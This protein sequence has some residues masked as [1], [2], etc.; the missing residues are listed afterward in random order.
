MENRIS[1]YDITEEIKALDEILI[2]DQGEVTESFDELQGFITDLLSK[3]TDGCV[4]YIQSLEDNIIAAESRIKELKHFIDSRKSIIENF[5]KYINLCMDKTDCEKF[6]GEFYSI[7]KTKP[8]KIVNITDINKIDMEYL[9]IP[10]TPQTT[11]DKKA[12]LSYLKSGGEC[13]GASLIDGKQSLK[14]GI[15]SKRD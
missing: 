5:K 1:L 3:K 6:V 9:V 11:V 2:Q 7:K 12:L 8:R 10:E 4:N 15:K 13:E 14:I